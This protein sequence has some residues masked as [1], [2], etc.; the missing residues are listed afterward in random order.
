V[1]SFIY[2]RYLYIQNKSE[3]L[4]DIPNF[5][6]PYGIKKYSLFSYK[7]VWWPVYIE[8]KNDLDRFTPFNMA[9][10]DVPYIGHP[11]CPNC[12]T[13]LMQKKNFFLGYTFYCPN[14]DC[15]FSKR[16]NSPIKDVS[17]CV[18]KIIENLNNK[19]KLNWQ[20]HA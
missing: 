1:I 11:V 9:Q 2:K 16:S 18:L 17:K 12:Q 3:T 15:C 4:H 20:K 8:N 7:G 19:G 14:E 6:P 5:Y 13:K 10:Y